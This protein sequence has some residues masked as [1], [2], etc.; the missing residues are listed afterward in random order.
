MGL[1]IPLTRNK[2][3]L[4]DD[5][6]HEKLSKYKWNCS[7][8]GYACRSLPR[9]KEGK[10]QLEWMHRV[11]MDAPKGMDVDHINGDGLDN[12][13]SNLRICTRSQNRKN[14]GVQ[15]NNRSQFKGVHWNK[16]LKKW[17]VD[18]ISDKKREYL[19]LFLSEQDAALA[20]NKAAIKHH[21][22][23]ARLNNVEV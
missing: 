23:F 11:I 2:F 14:S 18:I 10:R 4:V 22:E 7:T 12:R 16:R 13:R 5:I 6:D 9:P 1:E 19:G 20:Y 8:T 17:Q 21:G 3:T 15:K